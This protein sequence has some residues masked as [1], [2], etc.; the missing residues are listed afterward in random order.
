MPR[1]Q[2]STF[3]SSSLCL[4][5]GCA[6]QDI[7][8]S[9]C[10]PLA[11]ADDA[12][13]FTVPATASTFRRSKQPERFLRVVDASPVSTAAL[14]TLLGAAGNCRRIGG[15]ACVNIT[16][17]LDPKAAHR[18]ALQHSAAVIPAAATSAAAFDVAL[19]R[20]PIEAFETELLPHPGLKQLKL[21]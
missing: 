10:A 1:T 18:I 19:L 2:P 9:T 5:D 12:D 21:N 20:D 3:C 16:A 4:N 6:P 8:Y 13:A 11:S 14:E 17:A 7:S 15:A